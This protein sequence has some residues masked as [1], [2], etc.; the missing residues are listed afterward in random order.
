[1]LAVGTRQERAE[2]SGGGRGRASLWREAELVAA[3]A[4]SGLE[5]K[6]QDHELEERG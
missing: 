1:M 5:E 2:N 4:S 3:Y 6:G